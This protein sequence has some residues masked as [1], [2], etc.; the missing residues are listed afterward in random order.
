MAELYRK[1]V[2]GYKVQD[3]RKYENGQLGFFV[4]VGRLSGLMGSPKTFLDK[5]DS[6]AAILRFALPGLID[7]RNPD[8]LDP[9]EVEKDYWIDPEN[10]KYHTYQALNS[11]PDFKAAREGNN[12]K[13]MAELYR[14]YVIGY[15]ARDP[16]KYENGQLGFFFEIG[17][18]KGLM[19][20]PREF[21]DRRG[22]PAAL[23]RFAL[24]GLIDLRN[25]DSLD[26][27]EVERDYWTTPKMQNIIFIRR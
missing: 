14:K 15:K 16:Q 19:L 5:K 23:L 25:P 7:L 1:H 21:L 26:P 20:H 22:S 9:L 10:A 4:E 2:I 13:V 11:I 17:A 6:P 24:P 12:I 8:A 18:L 27:L 3:S